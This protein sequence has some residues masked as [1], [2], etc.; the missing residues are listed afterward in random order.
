MQELLRICSEPVDL[1]TSVTSSENNVT[2]GCCQTPS[3][4]S[5]FDNPE[6]S[7]DNNTPEKKSTEIKKEE[8]LM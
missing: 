2:A 1:N 3:I 8:I 4:P 6:N 5:I 7:D